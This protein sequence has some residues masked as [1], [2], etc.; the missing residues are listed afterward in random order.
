[1][2]RFIKEP[3][4]LVRVS[5]QQQKEKAL[6][7]TLIDCTLEEAVEQ[8]LKIIE[9]RK[10]SPV[11]GKAVRQVGIL[12]RE[13]HGQI[14]GRSKTFTITGMTPEEVYKL[15]EKKVPQQSTSKN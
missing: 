3:L 11:K 13:W 15:I 4:D 12:V 1:M 6:Y 2:K 9:N 14:G 8:L 5:I 7:I 10:V